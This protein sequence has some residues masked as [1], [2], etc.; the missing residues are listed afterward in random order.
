MGF[1]LGKA[2]RDVNKSGV[3][4]CYFLLGDDFFMQKFFINKIKENLVKDSQLNSKYFYLN[5]END[6]NNFFNDITSLSLFNSKD[7][8]II[9]NFNKLS[10]EYQSTLTTYLQKISN[11][12]TIIFVLNDLDSTFYENHWKDFSKK[13]NIEFIFVK[14]YHENYKDKYNAYK[15]MFFLGDNHFNENGNRLIANEILEKS[16]YLKKIFN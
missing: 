16:E 6:L 10:K 8:F 11:D 7:L 13:N 5:E 3:K 14:N 9:K 1:S 4:S 2:I 12:N 15:D